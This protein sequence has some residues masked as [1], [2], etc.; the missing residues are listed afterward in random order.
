MSFKATSN[1]LGMR[2][3]I[4]YIYS[5]SR[6]GS[7]FSSLYC[8]WKSHFTWLNFL[9]LQVRDNE[10]FLWIELKLIFI[11]HPEFLQHRSLW[12]L[13]VIFNFYKSLSFYDSL[14]LNFLTSALLLHSFIQQI[15]GHTRAPSPPEGYNLISL[16]PCCQVAQGLKNMLPTKLN[17]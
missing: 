14:S 2:Q 10:F 6:P 15:W 5:E 13:T 8:F 9:C 17:I 4:K 16:N 1:P 12:K 7:L 3:G 11:T